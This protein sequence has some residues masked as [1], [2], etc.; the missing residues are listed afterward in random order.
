MDEAGRSGGGATPKL[1]RFAGKVIVLTD[2]SNSSATLQF[3]QMFR[4]NGLGRILG[5]TTGGNL[6][7]INAE[8]FMFCRLPATGLE[9]DVP[10]VGFFPEGAPEDSGLVPD[11]AVVQTWRDIAA[12][13]DAVMARALANN[14]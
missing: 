5:E 7:G 8:K 13:R 3:C 14:T 6:R 9:V 1:P 4:A 12:G 11:V 2:A 10:L